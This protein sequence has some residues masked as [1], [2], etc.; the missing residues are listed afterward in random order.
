VLDEEI[1]E[2]REEKEGTEKRESKEGEEKKK[3]AVL[4]NIWI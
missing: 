4:V 2:K 3:S 1:S